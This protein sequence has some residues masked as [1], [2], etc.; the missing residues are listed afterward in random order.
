[1]EF[2]WWST[3]KTRYAHFSWNS[4]TRSWYRINQMQLA[5]KTI[6]VLFDVQPCTNITC[7]H[8]KHVIIIITL[9]ACNNAKYTFLSIGRW[10]WCCGGGHCCCYWPIAN[11]SNIKCSLSELKAQQKN[12]S[13]WPI[14]RREWEWE[15]TNI[16]HWTLKIENF[17][18][19]PIFRCLTTHHFQ[20]NCHMNAARLSTFIE[21][22]KMFNVK[23]F[24]KQSK[25]KNVRRK[26]SKLMEFQMRWS[27]FFVAP[28]CCRIVLFFAEMGKNQ[29]KSCNGSPFNLL[30]YWRNDFYSR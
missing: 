25:K 8:I 4:R 21:R 24:T 18:H 19:G 3:Q 14:L 30:A 2:V 28:F 10:C 17:K 13:P 12:D 9:M 22:W 29:S 16:E 23:I 1:M 7:I 26:C 5:P 15:W 11:G 6:D 27:V 20:G